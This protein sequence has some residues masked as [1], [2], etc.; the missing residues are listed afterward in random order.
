MRFIGRMTTILRI[1]SSANLGGSATREIG[2]RLVDR[3][4]AMHPSARLVERDLAR[5]PVPHIDPAFVDAMFTRPDDGALALSN[6]L[7][8]ELVASDAIVLEVP[9]YNF[10]VPS[11]LKAWLDHVV[12]SHR[13]FELSAS[14]V[15]GLL[16]GKRTYLVLG[17]GA[18]YEQGPFKPLD[19]LEPYLRTILGWMGLVDVEVIRVAGLNMGMATEALAA[20]RARVD[21]LAVA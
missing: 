2:Q 8:A 19:H 17:S 16:E 13:T 7:V 11:V 10:G 4:R 6:E 15:R 18:V 12:R 14:G 21:A 1:Q 9:M 3:L 5:N 20:A